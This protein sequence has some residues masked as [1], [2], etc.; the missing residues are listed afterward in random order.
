M[1]APSA[2]LQQHEPAVPDLDVFE[3][4]ALS[5]RLHESLGFP[6]RLP[7]RSTTSAVRFAQN[8]VVRQALLNQLLKVSYAV[9]IDTT[10]LNRLYERN[11]S[12][13]SRYRRRK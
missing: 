3:D 4:T 10:R 6:L 5:R 13:N 9:G 8:G 2:T 1:F 7:Q 11:V 12:L